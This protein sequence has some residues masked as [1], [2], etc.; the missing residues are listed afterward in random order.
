MEQCSLVCMWEEMWLSLYWT[1]MLQ[2]A[3]STIFPPCA[4]WKSK[5]GV[6]FKAAWKGI[7]TFKWVWNEKENIDGDDSSVESHAYI[8]AEI[9][10]NNVICSS[11]WPLKQLDK[12]CY[13]ISTAAEMHYGSDCDD[14]LSMAE[15]FLL[16]ELFTSNLRF[17]FE[18]TEDRVLLWL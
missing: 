10:T 13:T 18:R 7:K 8:L 9:I 5:S 12:R 14:I 2:P 6:F 16:T 15:L 3:N 17:G 11:F 4:R 1:G